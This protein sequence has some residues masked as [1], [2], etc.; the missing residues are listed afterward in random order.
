MERLYHI[1]GLVF[2][3]EREIY[4]RTDFMEK[5]RFQVKKKKI[6]KGLL[7]LEV[8]IGLDRCVQFPGRV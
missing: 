4:L 3:T 5:A 1:N 7:V 2:W 6:E 8:A